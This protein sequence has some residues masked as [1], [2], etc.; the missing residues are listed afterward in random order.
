MVVASLR[1]VGASATA[2]KVQENRAKGIALARDLLTE[3]TRCQFEDPADTVFGPESG[4]R[5]AAYD[6][7]DD[8]NGFEETSASARDG[9]TLAGGTGWKRRVDVHFVKWDDLDTPRAGTE[10]LKRITVTVTSPTGRVSKLIGLRA[11]TG[12]PD[13]PITTAATYVSRVGVTVGIGDRASETAS[14]QSVEPLNQLP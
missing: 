1:V 3:V 2:R 7:V 6:D 13:K 4:E 8:Y 14:V 12:A 10:K 5:R 11:S 9:T